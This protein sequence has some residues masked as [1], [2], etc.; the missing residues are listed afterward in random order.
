MLT[1]HRAE[2]STELADALAQ[3]LAVP[4]A[5]PFTPE[6]IAVPA[7]GIERWLTQRLSTVL[8]AEESDGVAANISFPSP[9]RLVDEAIGAA[10]GVDADDD[11]WAGQRQV[12]ALLDVID[13][14]LDE[15]WCGVL[16]AHLT[17]EHRI[18]RRYAT[19][20]HLTDL[21]RM[22]AAQRPQMLVDWAAG[23]AESRSDNPDVLGL[24]SAIRGAQDPEIQTMSGWLEQWG[25]PVPGE[26]DGMDR[27]GMPGMM[28]E[29]EMADLEAASG[30][31]FDKMFL[32]SMILHH[33]GAVQMAQAQQADGQYADAVDLAEQIEQ[34]QTAEIETM[35]GLLQG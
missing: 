13:A 8:G 16:K 29:Q 15:P 24:A 28:S 33:T 35:E 32:E 25:E 18:T 5:D 7:K 1:L 14:N 11:P 21:W 9:T 3:I 23:R 17:G 19:A 30:T 26:M 34:S 22:Y 12:W 4:L 20:S 31:S 10:S 6:V 2:R 27:G